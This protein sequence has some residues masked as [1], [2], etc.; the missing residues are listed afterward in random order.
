M[1]FLMKQAM[2]VRGGGRET[3]TEI[4]ETGRSI[5]VTQFPAFIVSKNPCAEIQSYDK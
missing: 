5:S 2:W 1:Y 4:F 3:Q